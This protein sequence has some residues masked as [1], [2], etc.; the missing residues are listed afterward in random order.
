LRRETSRAVPVGDGETPIRRSKK[1]RDINALLTLLSSHKGSFRGGL[2]RFKEPWTMDLPRDK[3]GRVP[4]RRG[5]QA[6]I[7]SKRSL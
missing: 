5:L 3:L 6:A 2:E 7:F 4:R 1:E